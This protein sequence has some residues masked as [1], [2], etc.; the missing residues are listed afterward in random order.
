MEE[1][2]KFYEQVV[3]FQIQLRETLQ[4]EQST[5]PSIDDTIPRLLDII[6]EQI[7]LLNKLILQ[8]KEESK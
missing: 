6:D 7:S 4:N 1:Q 3:E 5:N 2:F 8:L